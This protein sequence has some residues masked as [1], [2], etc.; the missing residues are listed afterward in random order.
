[1]HR[2]FLFSALL[3][4]TLTAF[5]PP[6]VFGNSSD[7]ELSIKVTPIQA[8][9]YLLQ[10][11]GGNVVAS[12]G[13]D[14][15][16][17]IDDDYA[18]Y[19]PAYQE[20]LGELTNSEGVPRLIINTHWH[21]DHTG[22]N[23]YWGEKGSVILANTQVYARMSTQQHMAFFDRTVEPSP[24]IALPMVTYGDAIEVRFN[25]DTL[26]V[27]HYPNGH[28]DG[29]SIVFFTGENVVHMGD[30]YFKDVFPFVDIGSGG[31]VLGFTANIEAVLALIDDNTVV[32][33]GHGSLAT[34][35]ELQS[36]HDML[37]TTTQM[38]QSQLAQGKTI[39]AIAKTGLGERWQ[40][41][42]DG[43]ISEASWIAFIGSSLPTAP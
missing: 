8:N 6:G 12:I 10:G 25:H 13:D 28:T 20:A 43:F 31:N 17:I 19:A 36:Y 29:D 22:S 33:P 32:V 3:C 40:S 34:K 21:G 1:M 14:G 5:K 7:D 30:H 24:A 42:G 11:R 2:H 9:L 35:A 41:W 37:V 23:G 26:K 16:L 39:E 18:E 4:L 15:I 38:V 27:Q